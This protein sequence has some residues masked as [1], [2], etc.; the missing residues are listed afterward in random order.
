MYYRP[1]PP[2]GV[3]PAFHTA[4]GIQEENERT[5]RLHEPVHSNKHFCFEVKDTTKLI[6]NQTEPTYL[7]V[8]SNLEKRY[9]RQS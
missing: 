3:S 9:N 2:L 4:V 5:L 6:D 1:V 7:S 8:P